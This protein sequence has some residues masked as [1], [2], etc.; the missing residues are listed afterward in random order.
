MVEDGG[1][2]FTVS[3][4]STNVNKAVSEL[5][6]NR[7]DRRGLQNGLEDWEMRK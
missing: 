4:I 7:Q 1:G 5:K 6:S 2:T 3:N